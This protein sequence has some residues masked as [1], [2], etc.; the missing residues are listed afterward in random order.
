M[1]RKANR[2]LGPREHCSVLLRSPDA[3]QYPDPSEVPNFDKLP[4]WYVRKY[5]GLCHDGLKFLMHRHFAYLADDEK[6]WDAMLCS[7]DAIELPDDPWKSP[8]DRH[9]RRG[10]A[11]RVWT[12]LPE[13]NKAWLEVVGVVPFESILDIDEFGDEYFSE[14]HNGV[15]SGAGRASRCGP[16]WVCGFTWSARRQCVRPELRLRRLR[17]CRHGAPVR[18][19]LANRG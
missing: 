8:G 19:R 13:P 10:E 3:V 15:R 17:R 16:A 7:D 1:K 14:P 9:E 4:Q 5:F 11:S 12:E 18:A 2:L 6:S